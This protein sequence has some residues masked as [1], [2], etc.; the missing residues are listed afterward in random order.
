MSSQGRQG[1]I[2]RMSPSLASRRLQIMAAA[3]AAGGGL[4]RLEPARLRFSLGTSIADVR[5]PVQV[6]PGARDIIRSAAAQ[7]AMLLVSQHRTFVPADEI[8]RVYL[9]DGYATLPAPTPTLGPSR[10]GADLRAAAQL[11]A[12]SHPALTGGIL[13]AWMGPGGRGRSLTALVIQALGQ[14]FAE[15]EASRRR[16]ETPFLVALALFDELAGHHVPAPCSDPA[17]RGWARSD[18]ARAAGSTE[19][20][21]RE[22]LPGPPLDRYLRAATFTGV[23]VAARTGLLRVARAARL[24]PSARVAMQLEVAIAPGPLLFSRGA[25]PAGSTLYGCELVVPV[26]RA[27]EAVTQLVRGEDPEAVVAGL[28]AALAADDELSRRA[29]A[30]VAVGRVRR[31]LLS[32]IAAAEAA[33]RGGRLDCLKALYSAPGALAQACADETA[34]RDLA[35]R[36]EDA[37]VSSG[38][39]GSGFDVAR[40]ALRAWREREP[41]AAFG[42]SRDAAR[43]EFALAAGALACDAALERLVAPAR[44]ALV[45]RTGAEAEGGA[46][47]EW[48]SGRLYRVSARPGPILKQVAQRPLGHL[49]VDVKDFT[50]RTGLLGPAAMAEFLRTE[51]Y[52]PI[53]VAAKGHFTGMAH[54]ADRGGVAVNGLLGDAISFSGDIEALVALAAEIRRLLAACEARL[55]RQVSVDAVARQIA[56]IEERFEAAGAELTRRLAAERAAHAAAPGP[57][58]AAIAAWRAE[59]LAHEQAAVAADRARATARAR[60]EGLEAG[61]F[62]SFGPAPVTILIDD[63]VFGHSR[64]AIAEKINESARGTARAAAGRARADGGL[65]DERAL[66]GNAALRHAWSVFVERSLSV[67]LTPEQERDAVATILAGEPAVS[68][69]GEAVREE[70]ERA[71]RA[72]LGGEGAGDLYN[73]G[74]ALSEEALSGFLDAV[75][76]SRVLRRIVL[77]VKDIPGE[78]R[79]RWYYGSAPLELVVTFHLDGRPAEMFRCAGRAAFKG[80][81]EVT[82]WELAAGSDGP[83]ALL[84]HFGRRWLGR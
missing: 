32:G 81:G 52:R 4:L 71:L 54:L 38:E 47:A 70:L 60:G 84:E 34:R 43:A 83:A 63:E 16:E 67:T 24:D 19:E 53:L 66:R 49:F 14:G 68:S 39:A 61:V 37:I 20:R 36:V 80:M 78:L 74:A 69:L 9:A 48:E 51:F 8:D 44:R 29:E 59:Q 58:E 10:G 77:E 28:A 13:C 21:V 40:N 7:L 57:R 35:L 64:V 55:A 82:V 1:N 50:R 45:P 46:D 15:M 42:L 2:C 41:A 79:S 26:P 18:Q 33:R 27:D 73:S 75:K 76:A 56:A 72:R 25:P 12:A 65:A 17:R 23:W 3:R 31:L 22:V 11:G 30:A 6:A 62:I 5:V